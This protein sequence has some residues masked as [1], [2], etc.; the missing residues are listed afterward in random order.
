VDQQ[1][2]VDRYAP[3]LDDPDGA[4]LLL[5]TPVAFDLDFGHTAPVAPVSLGGEVTVDPVDERIEFA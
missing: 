2:S 5:E 1:L 3:D 4:V